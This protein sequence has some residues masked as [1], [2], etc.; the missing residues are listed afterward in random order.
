[1][2]A[3]RVYQRTEFQVTCAS[4]EVIATCAKVEDADLIVAL[5]HKHDYEAY[6]ATLPNRPAKEGG[7]E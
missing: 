7:T 6:L 3:L 2:S 1:M 4:G 5:L